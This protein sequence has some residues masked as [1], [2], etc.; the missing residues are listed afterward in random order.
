LGTNAML[1]VGVSSGTPLQYQ[2]FFNGSALTGATGASVSLTNVQYPDG[3]EY[4]VVVSNS[5]GAVTSSM[6]IVR[7]DQPPEVLWALKQGGSG[8]DQ[9]L[10]TAVDPAGNVY[11]AGIFS[12]TVTFGTSNL[13]SSGGA[14]I[15]F[16]KYDSL[17]TLLWAKKYGGTGADS[18]QN[19]AVDSAGNVSLTG[20]FSGTATFGSSNLVSSGGTDI[21]VAKHDSDGNLLWL[22]R[23]GFFQND[24]GTAV[25]TDAAG[26]AY[27]T[28][29]YF[30]RATFE[31][32]GLTNLTQTNF[33]LVKYDPA[34]N[35]L[36]ARTT[37]NAGACQ[38]SGVAVDAATNVYVTGHLFGWANLGSGSIT[39]TYGSGGTVFVAK[40]DREGTLLWAKKGGTNGLGYG[41]NIVADAMGN[42]FAT[43]YVRGYGGGVMLTKYDGGGNVLWVRTNAISCCTGDYISVNGL[44]LDTAGNPILAGGFTSYGGLEGTNFFPPQQGFIV[45]YQGADGAPLWIFN[46]TSSPDERKA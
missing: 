13:V 37:T 20:F 5:F 45:K 26:N 6:A 17:G 3:G 24:Q 14:D 23:A 32:I 18:A 28:G 11:L 8:D 9:A 36:W 7:I 12:G 19:L 4:F 39:N 40:Y 1:T 34:G 33:F 35:A 30:D 43:S 38:G 31:G 21:F 44:S 16:A 29:S 46:L 15:F 41:Q 42:I 10:A 27:V 25:T 22:K 2:W